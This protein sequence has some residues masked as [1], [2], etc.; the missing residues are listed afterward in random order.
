MISYFCVSTNF[1]AQ[2]MNNLCGKLID[3]TIFNIICK[4]FFCLR[5]D[6]TRTIIFYSYET[7]VIQRKSK[8]STPLIFFGWLNGIF[9]HSRNFW[10]CQ[11]IQKTWIW[12]TRLD[13]LQTFNL[14]LFF[15]LIQSIDIGGTMILLMAKKQTTT[16]ISQPFI[17][18][19][20]FQDGMP[21]GWKKHNSYH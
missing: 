7:N 15:S 2:Q 9:S 1:N 17:F 10:M 13:T 20:W 19:F 5:I 12:K 3:I 8:L 6:I 14:G 18:W 4:L 16:I 21:Q 11:L